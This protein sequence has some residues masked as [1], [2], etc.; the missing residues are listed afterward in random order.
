[1]SKVSRADFAA[2]VPWEGIISKPATFG[3]TDI[4]QLAGAGFAIGQVPRWNGSKFVPYTIPSSSTPVAPPSA[5]PVQVYF[6]WDVPSLLPLQ[7]AYE[8]FPWIGAV[9]GQPLAFGIAF[10][11]QFCWVNATVIAND[12]IRLWVLNMNSSAVDL[13]EG[14]WAIQ[15][16]S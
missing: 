14:V 4:G 6:S 1:V 12:T 9:P 5:L 3:A 8:D 10:D 13:G 16:F 2:S 15:P 11:P 7:S